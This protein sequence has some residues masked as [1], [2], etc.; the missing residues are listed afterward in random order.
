VKGLS[1]AREECSLAIIC[2]CSATTLVLQS[3]SETW[4]TLGA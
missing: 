4:A 2:A 1:R 3:E